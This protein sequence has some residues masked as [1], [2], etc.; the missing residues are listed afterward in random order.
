MDIVE[1]VGC[2]QALVSWMVHNGRGQGIKTQ[3]V[4]H[5]PI[6][7]LEKTKAITQ[8]KSPGAVLSMFTEKV[9]VMV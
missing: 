5:L 8:M 9:S 4:R 3:E 7:V 2:F 1:G 6:S